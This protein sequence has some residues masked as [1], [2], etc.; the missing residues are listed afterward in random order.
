MIALIVVFLLTII[1]IS[2]T[3]VSKR[4]I[5]ASTIIGLVGG[6]IL[7]YFFGQMIGFWSYSRHS[8]WSFDYW[9]VVT[10]MWGLFSIGTY[11]LWKKINWWTIP[12]SMI[13][14][15]VY[16]ILRHSWHYDAP[17]W[18]IP[19]GWILMILTMVTLIRMI[20]IFPVSK[21]KIENN[22]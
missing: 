12:V 9:S 15:E 2:L 1:L 3:K 10:P 4:E 14:Y 6:L 7:D 11:C 8:Y 5:I 13:I 17:W 22:N 20:N 18:L 16:G 21:V 19:I